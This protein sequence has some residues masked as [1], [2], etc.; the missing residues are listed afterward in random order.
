MAR[1]YY[2][3]SNNQQSDQPKDKLEAISTEKSSSPPSGTATATTTATA[4][5]VYN[6]N[7]SGSFGSLLMQMQQKEQNAANAT[8]GS[9]SGIMT[10]NADAFVELEPGT[11][12]HA[13]AHDDDDAASETTMRSVNENATTTP[14]TAK[15]GTSRRQRLRKLTSLRRGG[16]NQTNGAGLPDA[17]AA[18]DG[19]DGGAAAEWQQQQQQKEEDEQQQKQVAAMDWETVKEL[20]EAVTRLTASED[21]LMDESNVEVLSHNPL[22]Q[23]ILDASAATK[24][25]SVVDDGAATTTLPLSRP[26][27]YR[28]RI[29]RG[30]LHLAVSIATSVDTIGEWRLFTQDGGGLF[31]LL[32]TIRAGARSIRGGHTGSSSS[33]SIANETATET[34]WGIRWLNHTQE[35]DFQAA[36]TACRSIRDI[37]ALSPEVSAVVTDGILRANTAWNGGF[38]VD[39]C[40]MLRYS[41]EYKE[42]DQD[43]RSA[44]SEENRGRRFLRRLIKPGN[45]KDPLAAGSPFRWGRHRDARLRCELYVTQLLLAL[46][47]ASDGA[48]AAIRSTPGLV[49][50]VLTCS[51][52]APKQQRRRW[53]RYPGAM[54]KWLWQQSRRKR[55][56]NKKNVDD[57]ATDDKATKRVRRPFLEAANVGTSPE[58]QV[59]RTAN[60][61]LAAVG[62]NKWVPKIPGQK[63]L[64]I[65]CLDGGGSRGMTAV[66]AVEC[67]VEAVGGIEVRDSFDIIAGTSTGNVLL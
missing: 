24:R 18:I 10:M 53:I 35:E 60:R 36:C 3:S 9:S 6:F 2:M 23:A 58:D 59:F 51:S 39:V 13:V 30:R 32:E 12:S 55:R 15:T 45:N 14:T 19:G 5:D 48:V 29:G 34:K 47:V 21:E 42:T 63:G 62:Y 56:K 1:R 33:S 66:K 64:R 22:H 40:T 37:C 46:T 27:H 44:N 49:N 38:M 65:L 41:S 57:T 50:A 28:D 31:P 54:A 11:A 17:T 43:A 7:A 16:K 26:E 4:A 67:M 52:Y 20:D 61:V 8:D 25:K